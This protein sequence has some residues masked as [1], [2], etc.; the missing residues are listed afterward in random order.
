ME[1][2]S[3]RIF[4]GLTALSANRPASASLAGNNPQATAST[5][6]SAGGTQKMLSATRPADTAGFAK[7]SAIIPATERQKITKT[8]ITS[9]PLTQHLFIAQRGG[10]CKGF[11]GKSEFER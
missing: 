10:F 5:A 9:P 3:T 1:K 4:T 8:A 11:D 6:P 2:N 7:T